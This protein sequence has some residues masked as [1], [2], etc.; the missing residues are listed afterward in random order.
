[1][2]YHETNTVKLQSL[3]LFNQ[4]TS[5]RA[6]SVKSFPWFLYNCSGSGSIFFFFFLATGHI[7][8]SPWPHN[9]ALTSEQESRG[10]GIYD[11]S[12]FNETYFVLL[13]IS[14]WKKYCTGQFMTIY[15]VTGELC[16]LLPI[17]F[18]SNVAL[19]CTLQLAVQLKRTSSKV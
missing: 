16:Y 14:K 18:R 5:H 19:N 10:A 17:P 8:Y 4:I 12:F 3:S 2:K 6:A 7:V 1:M 15:T 9:K 11:K 13:S